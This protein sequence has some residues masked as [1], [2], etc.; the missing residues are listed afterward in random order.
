MCMDG[1]VPGGGVPTA[2][3]EPA[4]GPLVPLHEMSEPQGRPDILHNGTHIS[5][6]FPS[7]VTCRVDI[8]STD[9]SNVH[10]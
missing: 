9:T 7:P 5:G 6:N 10:S 2:W 4:D 8:S 1:V 3:P